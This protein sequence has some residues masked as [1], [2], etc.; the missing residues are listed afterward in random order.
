[1][2][3]E[4]QAACCPALP[5]DESL[6]T[7]Q[8][9]LV[10]R[11]S[12]PKHYTYEVSQS[13]VI[14]KLSLADKKNMHHAEQILR[15]TFRITTKELREFYEKH[16]IFAL[17]YKD[18]MTSAT[19]LSTHPTIGM[20]NV[21]F[22]ATLGYLSN[23]HFGT[24]LDNFIKHYAIQRGCGTV[25][26][27]AL[28]MSVEFWRKQ[29]Y[30][31]FEVTDEF[32]RAY[33]AAGAVQLRNTIFLSYRPNL[34][35]VTALLE[36]AGND[37]DTF[38]LERAEKSARSTIALRVLARH[39]LGCVAESSTSSP[40]PQSQVPCASSSVPNG[41]TKMLPEAGSSMPSPTVASPFAKPPTK[42]PSP[43]AK[44]KP[45]SGLELNEREERQQRRDQLR[46]YRQQLWRQYLLTFSGGL[47]KGGARPPRRV[48]NAEGG[49]A[50]SRPSSGA[51]APKRPRPTP[52]PAAHPPTQS[53]TQA[54][55]T[56]RSP[57]HAKRWGRPN[58]D[59]S[60]DSTEEDEDTYKVDAVLEMKIE[61]GKKFF[62][63]KWSGYSLDESTWEPQENIF[64]EAL[65]EPFLSDQGIGAQ[66]QGDSS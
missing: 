21:V 8:E 15:S 10:A 39:G 4:Y 2:H 62:L 40:A 56:A 34:S 57:A 11:F 66:L 36:Q 22:F 26:V 44:R 64:D 30:G 53:S 24:V 49:S 28:D 3:D 38:L 18:R 42:A 9:R 65:L 50:R 47:K 12:E 17:W 1:M 27:T 25:L 37:A 52:L 32:T 41:V 51:Q 55:V 45:D 14:R 5:T 19:I 63:I 16:E 20:V 13:L 60:D 35:T 31:D 6:P 48:P 58:P 7:N 33:T 61:K 46:D 59:L 23:L 43:R 54:A 29:G